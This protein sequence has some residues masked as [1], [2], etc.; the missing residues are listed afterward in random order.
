MEPKSTYIIEQSIKLFAKKGF[1]STS[2]QEIATQCGISKGAFYLH[3]KSKDALLMDIFHYYYD[4]I[5]GKI[6]SI[7]ELN[8][9]ARQ[10]FLKQM[11]VTYEELAA[12]RDFIIMQIREQAIPFND[13]IEEFINKT[14]LQSYLFYH[15]HLRKI[16][17]EDKEDILW[18]VSLLMQG[19]LKGY[20]DL[21]II[22]AADV[23]YEAI[24]RSM[25]RY[26][27]YIV[28][29]FEK[30]ND[31]PVINESFIKN[32]LPDAFTDN[33]KKVFLEELKTRKKEA[34]RDTADTLTVLMEEIK[35]EEPRPAIL[36]ALAANLEPLEDYKGFLQ[37]LRLFYR[38]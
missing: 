3:F 33:R 9:D 13:N 21:I 14:R 30:H 32:I 19:I 35:R 1:S 5:Q 4:Q 34:D 18:E 26:A 24:S 23:D 37:E 28:E 38:I 27:D 20:M 2:V 17:G 29:G 16:Y 10:T 6:D 11:Q 8:L 12:H 31:Q 7:N 22:E 15:Y 36:K 25:L